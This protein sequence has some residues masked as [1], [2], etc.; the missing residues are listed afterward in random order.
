MDPL[1]AWLEGHKEK[2]IGLSVQQLSNQELLRKEVESPVRWFFDNLIHTIAEG[3]RER[4]EALLRG[5]VAMSSI[6]IDRHVVGLLPVLGVFKRAIWQEFEADPPSESPLALMSRLDAVI[7][8]AAEFMSK[9]EAAT[10]MDAASHWLMAHPVSKPRTVNPKDSFVTIAAHEL[11]TPLTVVEGYANMLRMELSETTQPRA[12]L[13]VRGMQS[14]VERL[15]ELIEDLIDISLIDSGLLKLELQPVWLLRMIDIAVSEAREAASVRCLIIEIKPEGIPA[16]PTVADPERLL[17]VFQ[18]VIANAIKY[19]PDGGRITLSG[20]LRPG[21]LDIQVQDTGVGIGADNLER[22]FEKFAGINDPAYHSSSKVNF[23]GGGAGLGLAIAKGMIEA[24]GGTIWA[25][26][27][28]YDEDNCPGSCFHIMVPLRSVTA[29]EG[30]S[31]LVA[32]AASTLSRNVP[33]SRPAV[34]RVKL[35]EDVKAPGVPAAPAAEQQAGEVR[36]HPVEQAL[37]SGNGAAS[38]E[39]GAG[40]SQDKQASDTM[41]PS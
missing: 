28:G 24:H 16:R 1:A 21:Y 35:E 29:G 37:G 31:P 14:G 15:R 8:S 20:T 18:K 22:I 32:T 33:E 39:V 6:P 41:P 13:M 26:S 4:L 10:L 11:R 5:W 9:V 2:L 40:E 27:S 25:E 17:K 12:A 3:Q 34:A 23:K 19:T 36:A 30:M 38:S 7:T